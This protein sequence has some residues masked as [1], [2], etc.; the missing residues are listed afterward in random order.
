MD[1]NYHSYGD[2]W[3]YPWGYTTMPTPDSALFGDLARECIVYNG[4]TWGQSSVVNYYT[5][6]DAKDW[7]YGE[8]SAKPKGFN[9]T[10]E[11]GDDFWQAVSDSSVI[12]SQ[13][14]ANLMPNLLSS[15]AA[16]VYLGITGTQ[17]VGGG[18][19]H[20]G[21]TVRATVT[22]KNKAM[23][24]TAKGVWG[25]L[26]TADPY[27]TLLQDSASYADFSPRQS[28]DNSALPFRFAVSSGC[29]AVH[30]VPFRLHIRGN[31]SYASSDTFSIIIGLGSAKY[32]PTPDNST[33]SAVYY[34][35]EDS[36][37]VDRAPV[38]SWVEIRSL[39]TQLTAL[40]TD[41]AT[42]AVT[43]PFTFKWYGTGYTTL[44]VC[45]N[46]W[47]SFG[48]NT[49]TAYSNTTIPSSTFATPTIFMNWDDLTGSSTGAWV[50]YY[51]DTANRR[52]IVEYDSIATLSG[53][54]RHKFQLIL[55]DSTGTGTK[56]SKYYDAVVQYQILTPGTSSSIGFQRSSTV[57][58]Q[59]LYNGV[60]AS[61][62]LPLGPN[63]AVRLTGNPSNPL[64]VTFANMSAQSTEKGIE[65]SWRTESELDCYQWEIERSQ[66]SET[67]YQKLGQ[68]AGQGTTS[69]ATDYRYT[70]GEDLFP[71]GYYYRLNEIDGSGGKRSYGPMFVQVGGRE[72]P[73]NYELGQSRPNPSRGKV[74][75]SFALKKAG[76]TSLT[77]YNITGQ[78]VRRLEGGELPAGYH[79]RSWDGRDMQGQAV[80]NGVYF[81]KLSSGEYNAVNK[82]TILR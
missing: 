71:G 21:D 22:L 53:G 7:W 1:I 16:G 56:A 63:R 15:E 66:Q 59:E 29:P 30:T 76:K 47:V 28:R 10:V 58:A 4:Y 70:D 33:P 37:G 77:I 51:Y 12:V 65:L 20:P 18:V 75:I 49:S 2:L 5:N 80:T 6:G 57:G 32:Q 13:F 55:Y 31:N 23:M 73:L 74:S 41:D 25:R 8:T 38:Y 68:V 40:N 35:V 78:A 64:G 24:D 36:D 54:A 50:G 72:L 19:Q 82:L 3:M 44:S 67:G 45:S 27:V 48:S 62:M 60:Y 14:N 52:F 69:Q 42:A 81:Y 26:T 34:A 43:L 39:G 79:T 46:G 9:F 11:I 17:V 61:T